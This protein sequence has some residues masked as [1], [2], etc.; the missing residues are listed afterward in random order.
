MNQH[1]SERFI[2]VLFMYVN[3]SLVFVTV[4]LLGINHKKEEKTSEVQ[5][6]I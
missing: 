5:Y 3:T 1:I 6:P 2:T 4:E